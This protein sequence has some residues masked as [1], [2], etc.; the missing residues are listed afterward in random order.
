MPSFKRLLAEQQL[1]NEGLREVVK[2]NA[3][4][5]RAASRHDGDDEVGIYR[6]A[7]PHRGVGLSR[8]VEHYRLKQPDKDAKLAGRIQDTSQQFPR[9]GDC[10]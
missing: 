2:K 7:P 4:P 3:N 9:F 1:V 5:G 10:E 8:A 6:N